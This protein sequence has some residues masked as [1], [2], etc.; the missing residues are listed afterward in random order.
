VNK[1]QSKALYHTGH[2]AD[3][4]GFAVGETSYPLL[5]TKL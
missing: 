4:H 3:Q 5:S 1:V 2:Q